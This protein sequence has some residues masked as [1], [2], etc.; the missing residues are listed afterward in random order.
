M[1]SGNAANE[2]SEPNFFKHRSSE[3]GLLLLDVDVEEE[4][5]ETDSWLS[6]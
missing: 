4:S 3:K 6:I 5:A 1:E 2:V